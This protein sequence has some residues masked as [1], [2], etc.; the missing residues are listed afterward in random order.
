MKK[1]GFHV[2]I[3][4]DVHKLPAEWEELLPEQHFLRKENISI[5]QNLQ[6]DNI[7]H[8]MAICYI[9]N[10]P[11]AAAYFQTLALRPHHFNKSMMS[12]AGYRA[13]QILIK[14]ARPKLLIAGHLFRHDVQCFYSAARL[15][16]NEAFLAYRKMINTV[17]RK[18][19][20][21]AVLVK[22]PPKPIADIF[23]HRSE[24]LLL[25]NDISMEMEIPKDWQAISHYENALKH[26]Y[27]QRMRKIFRSREFMTF[28]ELSVTD[29]ERAKKEIF[30]LYEKVTRHQAVRLGILNE[31]FLPELKKQHPEELKVWGIYSNEKLVA[32]T[33]AWCR[34]YLYDMFY[35]G[36]DYSKNQ[37]LNLYFNLLFFCI[38][39]AIDYRSKKLILGRTALDAKARLGAKPRYLNTFL[40]INNPVLRRITFSILERVYAQET[41]EDKHPLK[42]QV[43]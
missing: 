23:A 16:D 11:I 8:A 41:W 25:K 28:K 20:S 40:N 34:G 19:C 36:F 26:K 17:S 39:K 7:S 6:L 29:V 14:I 30:T 24:Y 22:E 13:S 18:H 38:E 12:A 42:L 15:T 9:K 32:F 35:I 37:E 43:D 5:Y 3:Y 21:N 4:D 33:S 31:D 2:K 27:A 1:A 10:A